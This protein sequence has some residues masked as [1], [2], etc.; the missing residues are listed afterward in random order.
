MTCQGLRKS[1]NAVFDMEMD[2]NNMYRLVLK[3]SSKN[4]AGISGSSE[5]VVNYGLGYDLTRQ[6]M[7]P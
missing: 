3:A 6:P 4:G 5:I 1:Y 7:V 2:H